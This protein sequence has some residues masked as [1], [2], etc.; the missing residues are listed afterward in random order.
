MARQISYQSV[1]STEVVTPVGMLVG[2]REASM[3]A[4]LVGRWVVN[5][6]AVST[7]SIWPF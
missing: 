5:T 4:K 1:A 6:V 3:G 2:N 7:T